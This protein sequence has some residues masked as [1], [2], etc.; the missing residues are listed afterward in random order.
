MSSLPL[1]QLA[2]QRGTLGAAI[3]FVVTMVLL[4]GGPA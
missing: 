1:V 3:L 2:S 4:T